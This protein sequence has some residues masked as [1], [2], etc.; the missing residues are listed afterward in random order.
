[1][2]VLAWL[3]LLLNVVQAAPMAMHPHLSGHVVMAT[4]SADCADTGAAAM[5]A[6]GITHHAMTA[7][8]V[9]PDCC[10]GGHALHCGC[11]AVAA[12]AMLLPAGM[13]PLP[14]PSRDRQRAAF[15]PAPPLRPDSPPLRP[16]LA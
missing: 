9:C 13:L 16:P 2:A 6:H 7:D 15:D 3:T 10:R 11:P 4:H 8:H 1:M 14:V 5:A 12:A